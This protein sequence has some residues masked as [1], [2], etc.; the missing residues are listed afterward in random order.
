VI[1]S[2][3]K[4]GGGGEKSLVWFTIISATCHGG[5]KLLITANHCDIIM[6]QL[7][8]GGGEIVEESTHDLKNH[9]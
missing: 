4:R 7:K 2:V 3:H 1:G 6:V 9:E 5:D 8:N